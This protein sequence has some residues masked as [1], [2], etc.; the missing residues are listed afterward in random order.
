[1]ALN[2]SEL[3]TQLFNDISAQLTTVVLNAN[4][5]PQNEADFL[6]NLAAALSSAIA[7]AVVDYVPSHLDVKTPT[8]GSCSVA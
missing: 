4:P 1:M 7:T 2:Q 8:G 5:K 6:N 3:Q